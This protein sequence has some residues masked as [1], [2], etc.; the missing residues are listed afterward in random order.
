MNIDIIM[1]RGQLLHSCVRGHI[2]TYL[3]VHL[4]DP[5]DRRLNVPRMYG[6]S[7]FHSLRDGVD[8]GCEA[9][10]C[11]GCKFLGCMRIPLA[12]EIVHDK[13]VEITSQGI[14]ALAGE[15]ERRIAIDSA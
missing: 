4:I 5:F 1:A 10:V 12:D 13:I 7:Y 11:F 2:E 6:I 9:H 8:I 14:E 3:R 15:Y